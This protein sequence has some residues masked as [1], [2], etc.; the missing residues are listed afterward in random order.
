MTAPSINKSSDQR[1]TIIY[2]FSFSTLHK[3]VVPRDQIL[4]HVMSVFCNVDK[5]ML[6][7]RQRVYILHRSDSVGNTRKGHSI[8]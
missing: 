5:L 6:Q 1:S 8:G 3:E 2:T 7:Q 4:P